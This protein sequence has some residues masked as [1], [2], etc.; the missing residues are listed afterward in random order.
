MV[1]DNDARRTPVKSFTAFDLDIDQAQSPEQP[2]IEP[3][4]D[5]HKI[6]VVLAPQQ[7]FARHG[8]QNRENDAS[9]DGGAAK[10]QWECDG[11]P[12][13]APGAVEMATQHGTTSNASGIPPRQQSAPP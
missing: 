1:G 11:R 12:R 8:L 6:L 5:M 13:Q 7:T 2:D 9:Q 3:E 4:Q 10:Q